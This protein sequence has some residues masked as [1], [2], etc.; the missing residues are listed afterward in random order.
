MRTAED[1]TSGV[2]PVTRR[3][4]DEG[5]SCGDDLKGRE[6]TGST[7]LD[8]IVM[9]LVRNNRVLGI[10]TEIPYSGTSRPYKDEY[11]WR[12]LSRLLFSGRLRLLST[13]ISHKKSPLPRLK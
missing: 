10:A 9:M 5:D 8:A 6:R 2:V 1:L 7:R 3:E 12:K 13:V 11:L 4:R